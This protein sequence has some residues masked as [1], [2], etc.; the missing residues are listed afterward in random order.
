MPVF[1]LYAGIIHAIALALLLP[2]LITL[3]GPGREPLPAPKAPVIDV[4]VLPPPE[5]L[6]D[7]GP[8]QT[9]ALPS[10]PRSVEE[11]A[12]VAAPPETA[13]IDPE[14]EPKDA[15][16]NLAPAHA[17]QEAVPQVEPSEVGTVGTEAPVKDGANATQDPKEA[18][19]EVAPSAEHSVEREEQRTEPPG[20]EPSGAE[21]PEANRQPK[22]GAEAQ[23]T[24]PAIAS[25]EAKDPAPAKAVPRAAKRPTAQRKARPVASRTAKTQ[26][27]FAPFNGMLSGLLNPPANKPK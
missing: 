20:A 22:N 11:S 16:R 9:S 26:T 21:A 25:T 15:A 2:M 23:G 6:T 14:K 12:P 17:P 24:A 18:A 10:A 19:I 1:L 8:E 27:K 13:G 5:T 4:L 3:P 7:A